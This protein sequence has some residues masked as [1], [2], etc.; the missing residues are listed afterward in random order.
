M[1]TKIIN[2]GLSRLIIN[3]IFDILKKNVAKKI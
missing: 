2:L 3:S 1:G